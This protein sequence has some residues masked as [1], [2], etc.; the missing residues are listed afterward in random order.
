MAELP[1]Q[2]ESRTDPRPLDKE[3][4]TDLTALRAKAIETAR[5]CSWLTG[6]RRSAGA[7]A[8]YRNLHKDL[9]A[10][11]SQLYRLRSGEPTEDLRWLYDNFRLIRTDLEAVHD[12]LRQVS[13]MPAV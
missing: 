6:Q 8:I 9:S 13:R 5:S 4:E 3:A 2:T 12:T 1:A 10:F 11:E 7:R